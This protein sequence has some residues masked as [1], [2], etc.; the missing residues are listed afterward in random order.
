MNIFDFFPVYFVIASQ[1]VVD[2]MG[3][4]KKKI[5]NEKNTTF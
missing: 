2:K 3:F 5:M 4:Q 1:G